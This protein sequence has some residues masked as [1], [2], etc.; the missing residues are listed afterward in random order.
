MAD[1]PGE[2]DAGEAPLKFYGFADFSYV[3]DLGDDIGTGTPDTFYIGRL[4]LYADADLGKNWRSMFEVRF[5]YLPNGS[6]PLSADLGTPRTDTTVQDYADIFNPVRWGGISIER[7]WLEKEFHPA[8][9][10]R[11]GHFLT[12]YGIWNVDH[13]SPAIIPVRRP[14][15]VGQ[16]LLPQAQT[17]LEA[18]GHL[19][20]GPAEVGYHLTLSNGRGPIDTYQ[21]LD[22]NKAVGGR[23]YGKLDT[24][25]GAF[26]LGFS[27]YRGRYTDSSNEFSVVDGEFQVVENVASRYDE[28]SL[29]A[30]FKWQWEGLHLQAEA[31]LNDR[32]YD[33]ATRP[34]DPAFFG[35]P[36]GF[37]PDS[38]TWGAYGLVG[39][40]TDFAALMPFAVVETWNPGELF[41]FSPF[42][43]VWFGLNSRPIPRVVIKGVF[44]HIF[45]KDVSGLPTQE[46]VNILETQVAW[47]F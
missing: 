25:A 45:T 20:F 5:M 44:V 41:I 32:A 43:S 34:T 47:S 11:G 14:F 9:T 4:N 7:A 42:T 12:P 40:R 2:L 38:R 3:F 28:L 33:E 1:I 13:G 21:D 23:L 31:I 30:D 22:N 36:P 19:G 8:L 39:Y 6:V 18:Y 17:G 27:G 16:G 37:V 24:D 46:D 10:L 15:C 29:A 26:T 35:G